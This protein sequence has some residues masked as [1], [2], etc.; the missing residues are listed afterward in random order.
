MLWGAPLVA[1]EVEQGT[2]RLVWAQSITR[3]RWLIVK[4]LMLGAATLVVL[5]A[6]TVVVNWWSAPLMAVIPQQFGSGWF[7]LL[8]IMPAVYGLAALA[9]GVTA[10]TFTRKLVPAIAI[11][12]L[13]FFGVRLAVELALRPNYMAAASLS[14]PFEFHDGRF[15]LPHVGDDL[16]WVMSMQTLDSTGRL[17]SD[18][19]GIEYDGMVAVCPE[20][21]QVLRNGPTQPGPMAACAQRMGFHVVAVYQPADRFWRFQVTEGVIFVVLTA[22][23]IGT[24][25][26]WLR[27]I[28]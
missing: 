24:S 15:E 16:G 2:H 22:A 9:I 13:A 23:L 26:W 12:L 19:N 6:M 25:A 11:T 17:I 27:R 14:V 8:G 28:T 21:A 1:R 5:I 20:L 7:D 3:R 10:G 18:G 4:V